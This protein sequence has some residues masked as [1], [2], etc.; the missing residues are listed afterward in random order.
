MKTDTHRSLDD[1]LKAGVKWVVRLTL[2]PSELL[3][4]KPLFTGLRFS[5]LAKKLAWIDLEER[6][7]LTEKN[8]YHLYGAKS[9]I[10]H[11]KPVRSFST[12]SFCPVEQCCTFLWSGIRWNSANMRG[13]II[14]FHFV[15]QMVSNEL[16]IWCIQG[17]HKLASFE[18]KKNQ[19]REIIQRWTVKG[20]AV[21]GNL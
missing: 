13:P 19:L 9:H 3:C 15:G 8:M 18:G 14:L 17:Y 16:I 10:S 6:K 12:H 1:C 11:L 7:T 4:I 21:S 20:R 5:G 2:K